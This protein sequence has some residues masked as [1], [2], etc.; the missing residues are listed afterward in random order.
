MV[1]ELP[2]IV[3]FRRWKLTLL[4][5]VGER[6][7]AQTSWPDK[8][9]HE[10]CCQRVILLRY[11][12][13]GSWHC[14]LAINLQ[15]LWAGVRTQ[16][17]QKP[18]SPRSCSWENP[19]HLAHVW[20]QERYD[21]PWQPALLRALTGWLHVTQGKHS[22]RICWGFYSQ[23]ENLHTHQAKEDFVWY[24]LGYKSVWAYQNW[25]K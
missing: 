2:W 11:F 8:W 19:K 14:W 22:A 9:Q 20:S 10:V 24:L 12:Q 7:G 4:R 3:G 16:E 6:S 5:T 13:A 21:L 17:M 18:P 1:V 23:V 15:S 25:S